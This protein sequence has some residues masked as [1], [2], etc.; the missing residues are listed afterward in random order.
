M[1]PT[2]MTPAALPEELHEV[3]APGRQRAEAEH[4]GALQRICEL[5]GPL[6]MRTRPE[7]ENS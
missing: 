4:R 6:W 1:I 2:T 3:F 5:L 7:R